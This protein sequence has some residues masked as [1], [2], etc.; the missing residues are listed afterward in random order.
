MNV[1]FYDRRLLWKFA[2]PHFL[3]NETLGTN[4]P[5][6]PKHVDTLVESIEGNKR[7]R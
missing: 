6:T 1:Y 2:N 3:Q 5:T 7:K 4:I